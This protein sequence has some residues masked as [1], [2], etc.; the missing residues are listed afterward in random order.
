MTARQIGEMLRK[1]CAQP[2]YSAE[3]LLELRPRFTINHSS[4]ITRAL[5]SDSET[6][7]SLGGILRISYWALRLTW[8][9][10]DHWQLSVYMLC[11]ATTT[12]A[13]YS[14]SSAFRGPGSAR[15]CF[16]KESHRRGSRL[17]PERLAAYTTH[18]SRRAVASRQGCGDC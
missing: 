15:I 11:R 16:R 4:G 10:T 9:N 6:G 3:V 8:P 7:S 14:V 17:T 12:W 13:E 5:V 1:Q 18:P 2:M